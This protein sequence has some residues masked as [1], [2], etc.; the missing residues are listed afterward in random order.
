MQTVFTHTIWVGINFQIQNHLWAITMLSDGLQAD[1]DREEIGASL[2]IQLTKGRLTRFT[3][4][5]TSNSRRSLDS[6]ES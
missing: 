5:Y 4:P 6:L 2:G 1:T 3:G